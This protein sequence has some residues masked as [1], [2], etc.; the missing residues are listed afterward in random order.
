MQ[1]ILSGS[2]SNFS[3]TLSKSV[4][5]NI[6]LINSPKNEQGNSNNSKVETLPKLMSYK[7]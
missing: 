3:M 1:K 6:N 4:V 2:Q 5:S 7:M